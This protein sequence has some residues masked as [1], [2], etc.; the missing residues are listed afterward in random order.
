MSGGSYNRFGNINDKSEISE[1][2][3]GK[4]GCIQGRFAVFCHEKHVIQ[5]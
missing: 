5:V 4:G 1:E 3:N 2:L